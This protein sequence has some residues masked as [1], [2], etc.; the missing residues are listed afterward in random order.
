M[1]VSMAAW[2]DHLKIREPLTSLSLI[3]LNLSYLLPRKYRGYFYG[4][5]VGSPE[6]KGTAH[7][8]VID[9]A[10]LVVSVTT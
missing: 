3:Q 5:L 8:S 6:D 1:R 10:E 2:L 4:N 7:I 9:P